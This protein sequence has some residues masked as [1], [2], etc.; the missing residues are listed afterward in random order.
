MFLVPNPLGRRRGQ[1]KKDEEEDKDEKNQNLL[2][3]FEQRIFENYPKQIVS[4]NCS[5]GS[6]PDQR[7]KPRQPEYFVEKVGSSRNE[8]PSM[9]GRFCYNSHGQSDAREAAATSS[10]VPGMSLRGE[11]A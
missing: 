8:D 4:E 7:G 2:S 9:S 1:E 5:E 11:F 6:F 10:Q 3:L